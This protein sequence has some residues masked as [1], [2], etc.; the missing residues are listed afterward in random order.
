MTNDPKVVQDRFLAALQIQPEVER[1]KW[2]EE[3]CSDDAQLKQRVQA[4]LDAHD[5]TEGFGGAD[6][7][8]PPPGHSSTG[9]VYPGNL[10]A[11]RYKLL[12]P[13]GEGGMG[14]VWLAEQIE[15][16][17]RRVAIKLVKAGMDSRQVLARFEA[18]R[19]ALALMDHPNIAK[20][21]DGGITAEG[22]PFFVMEY[23]KGIPLTEYCDKHQLTL[24]DR[25]ELMVPICQA[26]Q[27]A[28]Q[29]GIIH[30]DLKP[31]NVLVCL[32]DGMPIPR[33][34][35]FGLA[36]AIHQ[37]LT[38]RTLF[39][40]H[41]L[42]LG[43][44]LYMSPEQAELNNLDVDTRSDVYSLGVLLYELLTGSTPLEKAQFQEAALTEILR[45]IKEVDPPKPSTRVSSSVALASIAAQRKLDPRLLSK[46]ICGELDWIVMRAMEKERS[47]RYD[48][49]NAFAE[50]IQRFL[51]Q[52]AV[53]ARP[54]STVYRIKK[55]AQRN[56]GAV[57]AGSIIAATLLLGFGVSTWFAVRE[58]R[59]ANEAGRQREMALAAKV[60]AD[61]QRISA[62]SAA[63]QETKQR[64]IA[65][66]NAMEAIAAREAEAVERAA[67]EKERDRV[68]ALN[69]EIVK[70]LEVQRRLRYT[71][72]MN[73][74]QSAWDADN[75]GRVLELLNAHRPQPG[76]SDLRG[77]EWHYWNRQCHADISTVDF[78]GA[79]S[80]TQ[81]AFSPDGAHL[82][83][84]FSERES[85][86]RTRTI[87]VLSTRKDAEPSSF[88]LDLDGYAV[89]SRLA[90]HPN[91]RRLAVSTV[92]KSS[93]YIRVYDIKSNEPL[94]TIVEPRRIEK[95]AGFVFV[96]SELWFS[97]DGSSIATAVIGQPKTTVKYWDA[98]TGEELSSIP[99]P[100]EF[101]SNVWISPDGSTIAFS[102]S[103][104]GT[105][106]T[107]SVKTLAV[108]S[109]ERSVTLPVSGLVSYRFSPDSKQ[110]FVSGIANV[111]A[112]LSQEIG[113]S[114]FDVTS[115]AKVFS[116][117]I[118]SGWSLTKFSPDG[119]WF[120]V[121]KSNHSRSVSLL[122][123]SGDRAPV[124]LLGHTGSLASLGFSPDSQHLYTASYGNHPRDN[125]IKTWDIGTMVQSKMPIPELA[126]STMSSQLI[127]ASNMDGKL[128]ASAPYKLNSW[129]NN[130][131]TLPAD[132]R[133]NVITVWDE[134]WKVLYQSAELAGPVQWIKFSSD[135]RRLAACAL[136]P[137]GDLQNAAQLIVFDVASGEE[138]L[139]VRLPANE[140]LWT[141]DGNGTALN[142][143]VLE[144]SISP[145]GQRVATVINLGS[146]NH[147]T[148][149][150]KVWEVDSK[151]VIWESEAISGFCKQI[152]I[153]PDGERIVAL[154][155]SEHKLNAWDAKDGRM[156]WSAVDKVGIRG[157]QFSPDGK[158][159]VSL[160]VSDGVIKLWESDSGRELKRIPVS[161]WQAGSTPAITLALSSDNKKVAA[162]VNQVAGVKVWDVAGLERE[163]FILPTQNA[164]MVGIAFSPDNRRI[165]TCTNS[166]S[167][168]DGPEGRT[169]IWD[170]ENGNELLT[171]P[172][173][174]N[175]LEFNDKGTVLTGETLNLWGAFNVCR[176]DA[177][178]LA[179]Q[180]EA[181]QMI[182]AFTNPQG[183]Q[184]LPILSEVLGRIDADQALSEETRV[185]AVSLVKKL[186]RENELNEAAYAIVALQE[187]PPQAYDRALRYVEEACAI[188]ANNRVSWSIR[189]LA[190]FRLGQ[191]SEALIALARS[192]ELHANQKLTQ[193]A[194][195]YLT[196]A[197]IEFKA[198]QHTESRN[199]LERVRTSITR[200][201]ATW[202]SPVAFA[203]N[204]NLWLK[205]LSEAEAL[206]GVSKAADKPTQ[207]IGKAFMPRREAIIENENGDAANPSLPYV[208]DRVDRDRLWFGKNSIAR[209]L[210]IPLEDS[211]RYYT[212]LLASNPQSVLAHNYLGIMW[213]ATGNFEKA[214]EYYTSAIRLTSTE[215]VLYHNRAL[216]WHEDFCEYEK[217][218]ADYDEAIRLSPKNAEFHV[219]RGILRR[220][221]G[222][223]DEAL[224]NFDEAIR[225]QPDLGSAYANRAIIWSVQGD[226][227]K[228]QQD[229][230]AAI[231]YS[232]ND[233]DTL[234]ARAWLMATSPNAEH[235]NGKLAVTEATTACDQLTGV[236]DIYKFH[237]ILAAAYAETGD[238]EQAIKYQ[239]KALALAPPAWRS[240][241]E[242]RKRLYV[243]GKP[244]RDPMLIMPSTTSQ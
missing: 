198:G 241:Y 50:D 46:A 103:T 240:E 132:T 118:F 116:L 60:E 221:Q 47:R 2:L 22:R 13:I 165:A 87:K 7:M 82:A 171:L 190:H 101:V 199:T 73:L 122:S 18:E 4:L 11:G 57:I 135:G 215:P 63:S 131:N 70:Q 161:E 236:A 194:D 227:V 226:Q 191:S 140:E 155:E 235:R 188:D 207:W 189:G 15:P 222:H 166:F 156:L 137:D 154:S 53:V 201:E 32:Y 86:A 54:V 107:L 58:S 115:G 26:I 202:Q 223:P 27:H 197:M 10:L 242:S 147:K 38:E 224:K 102:V 186:R 72:D 68:S 175:Y 119:K 150:I 173:A 232:P 30:R 99:L 219:S 1:Q 117:P 6:S 183:V 168:N 108:S 216:V 74:I 125:S 91:G 33:V 205:L 129:P 143:S 220:Q 85:S 75:V 181:E 16:V 64:E 229:L 133:K 112:E 79:S 187:Q 56:W 176:W 170:A 36:K 109:P 157:L 164:S 212:R 196:L 110:L 34:I 172:N 239:E 12:E 89:S 66:Q 106:Q 20:V 77:F 210:A 128:K 31:S 127:S 159:V 114:V 98:A 111:S 78:P 230:D 23:V 39:T 9:P 67:A 138:R 113:G 158:L 90:W 43:T 121:Y 84:V 14:T 94:F 151:R 228:M 48:T 185:A 40:G 167:T 44:P 49:P 95:S 237:D 142:H 8:P 148:S 214:I 80:I 218:L 193:P 81:A 62:E 195:D 174:A 76:Q 238:F 234:R 244:Y 179:T 152:S 93:L 83:G 126:K 17:R 28:H 192:Q 243:E 209:Q 231:G 88:E 153:S 184:S 35:D 61:R 146:G 169:K 96:R 25:L 92:D 105:D 162:Y 206:V 123:T 139:N 211:E 59:A 24:R 163:L 182:D 177:R 136:N 144:G 213:R 120:A 124:E 180:I 5:A 200:N 42:V 65:Q 130:R 160:T 69:L 204:Q 3:H 29:K 145:D 52:E 233:P 178:P 141:V 134:F 149:S 21:L 225:L 104:D 71:S 51:N 203:R 217:A 100:G 19:Q 45:L 55:F 37:P 208:I 97:P 41:G